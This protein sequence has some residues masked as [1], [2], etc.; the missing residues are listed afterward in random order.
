MAGLPA[1][2]GAGQRQAASPDRRP[3]RPQDRRRPH[4]ARGPEPRPEAERQGGH[5]AHGQTV[6]SLQNKGFF[7]TKDGQ[8]LSNQG[9]VR[10]YTDE[11]V[12]YTLRYG[13]SV[14][15]AGD[16][17]TAGLADDAEKKA[18][19]KDKEKAKK[20]EGTTENRY[21]MV[22]VSFDPSL[23]TKSKPE[24][25]RRSRPPSQ[26]SRWTSR[27]T[28]LLPTPTIPSTSPSRKKPRKRPIAIRRITRR[29]S[30]TARRKWPS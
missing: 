9:D 16:E 20:A 3:G 11:G 25:R 6:A 8:L 13:G 27:Q 5:Q 18:D 2:Q 30:P 24:S 10:V 28:R 12:V 14:F 7:L 21:L 23:I 29:R 19:A 1:G 15:G 4:Q 26:A 17:L 22:T